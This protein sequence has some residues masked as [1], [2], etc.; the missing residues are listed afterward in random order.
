[1]SD[2]PPPAE[3]WL[4]E[5][6]RTALTSEVSGQLAELDDC[7]QDLARKMIGDVT[8]EEAA[9]YQSLWAEEALHPPEE[10]ETELAELDWKTE[11]VRLHDLLALMPGSEDEAD[12]KFLLEIWIRE[13]FP[14][15]TV[16][17]ILDEPEKLLRLANMLKVMEKQD[18]IDTN[19]AVKVQ[20]ETY[21][22]I[23]K[24]ITD[25]YKRLKME[26]Q[27]T[28]VEIWTDEHMFELCLSDDAL[29][30]RSSRYV[31]ISLVSGELT[32]DQLPV[33]TAKQ[34]RKIQAVLQPVPEII[35]QLKK[36][37]FYG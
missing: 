17:S 34:Q 13:I 12:K 8:Y 18:T 25:I 23:N 4:S 32:L 30:G 7:I 37:H 10:L 36:Y 31:I 15:D 21:R 11:M 1:M 28:I 35:Q 14:D 27:D 19:A 20:F 9:F 24:I 22:Q 16:L 33:V 2:L 3:Q 6:E 26:E 29:S 5:E